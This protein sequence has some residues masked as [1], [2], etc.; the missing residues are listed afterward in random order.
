MHGHASKMLDSDLHN[1]GTSL[2]GINA[3]AS[4]CNV[5]LPAR[6]IV[7]CLVAC[8]EQRIHIFSKC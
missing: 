8:L 3:H 1:A 4:A 5:L 6:L 7:Y 2:Q